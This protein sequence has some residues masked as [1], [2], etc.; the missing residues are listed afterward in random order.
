[1]IAGLD[2]DH[3]LYVGKD[4]LDAPEAATGKDRGGAARPDRGIDGGGGQFDD[5]LGLDRRAL[6][7]QHGGKRRGQRAAQGHSSG[8]TA[9][10]LR[11]TSSVPSAKPASIEKPQ[12]QR[13]RTIGRAEWRETV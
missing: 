9:G 10:V 11:T 13:S 8:G 1:M 6:R 12:S 7:Q 4:T 3:A 2:R 5:A